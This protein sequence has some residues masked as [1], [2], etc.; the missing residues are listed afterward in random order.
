VSSTFVVGGAE[1]VLINLITRLPKDRFDTAL[2][3]L[4]DAG[5][6]GRELLQTGCDGVDRLQRHRMDPTVL[7]RLSRRL[8]SF[9]P[10]VLFALD[11][12]N[13]M[14]WGGLSSLLSG[15]PRRVVASHST[16]RMN[17]RKNFKGSDRFFLASVD[18]VVALSE[19]HAQYLERHEGIDPAKIRIIENGIDVARYAE[20]PAA[21]ALDA[22][23]KEV[24]V[25]TQDHVVMMVAALRPEKAHEALLMAARSI[26]ASREGVKFLIVG[27]GARRA[28]LER[29]RD[30]LDLGAYVTF[31]GV[32]SD[33]PALLAIADTVVLPSHPAVETLPMAVLEAMAAGVPV[34]ASAVGSVPDLIEDK[35][36]GLLIRPA[37]ANGLREAICY[38]IDNKEESVSLAEEARATVQEKYTIE[39]MVSSYAALF[40][41]LTNNVVQSR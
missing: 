9:S 12:H 18:A 3:F 33:V 24:G 11:H 28:E 30:D 22:L 15:V 4:K 16:G 25:G 19:L 17:G 20:T 21:T 37:D 29:M 23:R 31:L 7:F 27:D 1:A 6:L 41:R 14:L 13:A 5:P 36:N 38:I 35:R 10:D 32:R 39:R 40:E 34:V 2:Y 8:N 26:V